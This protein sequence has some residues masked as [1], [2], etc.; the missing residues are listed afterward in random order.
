MKY[1]IGSCKKN[2]SNVVDTSQG[3]LVLP[4]KGVEGG[5]GNLSTWRFDQEACRKGLTQ[6]IV[7]DEL[8]FKFVESKGFKK[9]IFVACPTFYIPSRTTMIWDVYQFYLDKGSR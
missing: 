7:I 5:E 3:Q 2:P 9:F 4:R 6:M 8:P 1:H